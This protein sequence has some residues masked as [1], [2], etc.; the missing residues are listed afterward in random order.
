MFYLAQ[1]FAFLS[2]VCLLASFWQ[3]KRERILTLQI[4][5]SLFDI[6]Q[7]F[8]LGAYTGG[9]ISFLGAIRAYVFKRHNNHIYLWLFLT[10][11]SIASFITFDGIISVIPLVAALTYTIIVWNKREKIIRAGSIFV[12]LLWFLYDLL[13]GAYVSLITDVVLIVSNLLAVYK[14]D[15]KS[16]SWTILLHYVK[17]YLGWW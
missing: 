10:L 2:S 3:K 15:I 16:K 14:L 9:L 1:V 5:D 4:L 12:F 11:Y 13:V 7:Y 6:L 8:L 17:I